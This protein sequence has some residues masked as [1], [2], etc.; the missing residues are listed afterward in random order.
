MNLSTLK[1]ITLI[2]SILGVIIL[3]ISSVL[4]TPKNYSISELYLENKVLLEKT[5]TTSGTVSSVSYV[6]GNVFLS[7]CSFS[8][9]LPAVLFNYSEYQ[10][11]L[12]DAS[13]SSSTEMTFF[14]KYTI[15]NNSPELIVYK[16]E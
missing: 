1:L 10:K 2:I 14:G 4:Y 9:C 5:I 15:Y 3:I 11:S 13:K 8:R 16:I 6:N 12:L 7:I